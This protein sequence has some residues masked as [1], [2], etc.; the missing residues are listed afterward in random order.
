MMPW[1]GLQFVILVFADHTHLLF[2]LGK[3]IATNCSS[4]RSSVSSHNLT[5]YISLI[6]FELKIFYDI[7]NLSNKVYDI[8][9]SVSVNDCSTH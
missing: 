1:V 2:H 3:D 8:D 9:I 7:A 4:I 6:V 5:Q